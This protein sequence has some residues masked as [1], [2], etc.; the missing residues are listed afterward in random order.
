[1]KYLSPALMIAAFPVL[2]D[3][4]SLTGTY[5]G[6]VACERTENGLPGVFLLNLDIRVHQNGNRLDIATWTAEDETLQRRAASL[7]SGKAA[8][9]NGQVSGYVAACRPD[10]EYIETIRIVPSVKT[11]A[12]FGFAADTVFVTEALPGREGYLIVES[13]RWVMTRNSTEVPEMEKCSE[14]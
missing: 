14:N 11:T 12:D 4:P 7:Y 1:M 9:A 13:C 6:V 3:D 10:F 5:S 2:A 8:V